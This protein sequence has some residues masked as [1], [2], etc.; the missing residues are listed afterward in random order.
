M[1]DLPQNGNREVKDKY[2]EARARFEKDGKKNIAEF[3][4]LAEESPDDPV[5]SYALLYAG[6]GAYEE[7]EYRRAQRNFEKLADVFTQASELAEEV[8]PPH[9]GFIH[10]D[11]QK[12]YP[13]GEPP[14]SLKNAGS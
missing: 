8:S 13:T 1:P 12:K 11:E 9:E 6:I 7:K 4:R 14:N 2:L 5:A 10:L 3:E